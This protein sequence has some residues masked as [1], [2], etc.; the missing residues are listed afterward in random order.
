M[1]VLL[2]SLYLNVDAL[3]YGAFRLVIDNFDAS[4]LRGVPNVG[5]TI[6]LEV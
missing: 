6:G 1:G 5:S 2:L 3:I 4:D